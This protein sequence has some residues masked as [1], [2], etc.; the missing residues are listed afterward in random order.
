MNELPH[1][2]PAVD[3]ARSF[4][5][6]ADAYDRGRPSYPDDAVTQ[7]LQGVRRTG[8]AIDVLELAAGTG[9]L[10]EQLLA[11][12]CS[13]TATD[14]SESMLSRLVRRAPGARAAAGT[15]E[16]VPLRARSVDLVVA[17]QAFH[18]FD[19]E[20][21]LQE[22]ARVLRPGGRLAVVWSSRDE[23]IPWVRRLGRLIGTAEQASDPT[24]AIDETG[25][26]EAVDRSTY[27]FWQP[28]DQDSLRDLVASR[29]NVAVMPGIERDRLL[30]K[31]DELYEEYGR[32]HDGM[33]LPY[34][35][36][37]CR[38]T[39]LP[40]AVPEAPEEVPDSLPTGDVGGPDDD[41][42]LIDFR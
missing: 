24:A 14:P 6:V 8:D 28:L 42:L 21:A 11:R 37:V 35:T 34:V 36:T 5:L 10:T 40:W 13:V 41:A 12:G 31:V 32:G 23:R 26:F 15:A 2:R 39:V 29:S 33:L 3:P 27:R 18:W 38:T 22:V 7:L 30:R 19:A 16:Q 17:A 25:M 20:R 9:K 1:H 4:D